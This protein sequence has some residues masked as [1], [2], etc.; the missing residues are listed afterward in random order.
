[1]KVA[2]LGAADRQE[3]ALMPGMDEGRGSIGG[4]LGKAALEPGQE[5]DREA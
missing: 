3:G 4:L 2:T 5:K 1:M